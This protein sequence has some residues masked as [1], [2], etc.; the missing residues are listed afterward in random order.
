MWY[1]VNK[2]RVGTQQVRPEEYCYTP[3]S[4]TKLYYP[5]VDSQLDITW[6]TTLG[7]SLT[8]QSKWYKYSSGSSD[9]DISFTTYVW[10]RFFC[11]WMYCNTLPTNKYVRVIPTDYWYMHFIPTDSTTSHA[12]NAV[13][14]M[15]N[16]STSPYQNSWYYSWQKTITLW[17]WNHFAYGIGSDNKYIWVLN[18]TSMW[19]WTASWTA[20]NN[21]SLVSNLFWWNDAFEITLL[22][23]IWE[24][25]VRTLSEIQAYYNKSKSYYWL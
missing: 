22:D 14:V 9:R 16:S 13:Y 23:L 11:F 3:T 8:Q 1:K 5:F 15:W 6:N 25:R 17:Q 2:I 18:W 10:T 19:S 21:T 12:R 4:N 7:K 24:D 20:F